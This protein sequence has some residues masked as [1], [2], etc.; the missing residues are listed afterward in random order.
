MF[1][2]SVSVISLNHT[3]HLKHYTNEGCWG[4]T[5]LVPA[6]LNQ[7]S[8]I[9]LYLAIVQYGVDL[10]NTSTS[11]TSPQYCYYQCVSYL[12]LS[13][14]FVLDNVQNTIRMI[15]NAIRADYH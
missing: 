11:P 6:G 12:A 15:Q 14:V 4:A 7:S 1:N 5:V 3:N 13:E 10:D 8:F 2:G 9:L